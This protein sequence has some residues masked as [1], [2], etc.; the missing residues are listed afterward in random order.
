MKVKKLVLGILQVNCYIAWEEEDRR[1]LV[2]DPADDAP[3]ILA[4]LEEDHLHAKG[5]LLTHAHVDHIRAI[6]ALARKLSLPVW[7][8]ARE[9]ELYLSPENALPPWMPAVQGLPEPAEVRHNLPGLYF[10]VLET[11]GH[12]PGGVAYYFYKDGVVFTGDTL[13]QNSIGRTDLP[14]GDQDL[15]LRSIREKLLT[16]PRTTVVYPGHGEP[17]TIGYEAANNPF[18]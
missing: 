15:L 8:Q 5:M 10:E 14:G 1:A 17:T 7:C 13:F 18:I 11:P 6:P 4:A 2:I 16:L 9:R 3:A 12:T